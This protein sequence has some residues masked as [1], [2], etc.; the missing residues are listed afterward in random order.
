M[1][2]NVLERLTLMQLLETARANFVTWKIVKTVI[3][4]LAL[5]EKEY[6]KFEIREEDGQVAWN[7]EGSKE[8]EI[9]IGEVVD[10]LIIKELRRLDGAEGLEKRHV[11]LYEKFAEKQSETEAC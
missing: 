4:R 2:L 9:E 1:K 3:E 6:K 11:S 8:K 7:D 10:N 5:N